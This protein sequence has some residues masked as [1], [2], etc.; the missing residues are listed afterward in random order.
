MVQL[1]EEELKNIEGGV[2]V[3]VFVGIGAAVVFMAGF[4]DGLTR[5]LKCN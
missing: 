5:P 1:K 3:W 2:S 4:L